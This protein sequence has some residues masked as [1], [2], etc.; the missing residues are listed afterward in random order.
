MESVVR[1]L[2][3]AFRQL[4]AA[5][6]FTITALL[7]LS[8]ATGA[9][10]AIFSAV[11]AVL[12]SPM[13]VRD[14][15]ALVV[16]WGRDPARTE[17]VVELTYMDIADLGRATR[18]LASTAAVGSHAWNAVL[19]G[20]GE[21]TRLSYAGV[22]GAFFET[23]GAQPLLGRVIAPPDDVPNAESVAVMSHGL[24]SRRFGSD[25]AIVGA[26][27]SRSTETRRG[28]SA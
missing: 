14:P 3:Q 13:S 20:V 16:G 23:L 28:S 9:A 25:P 7:T 22:S 11:Y 15:Q 2:R 24:W 26:G 19:D 17:G 21:P 6:G 27:R 12:L 8:L 18:H 10:T 1:Q 4:A 5:P